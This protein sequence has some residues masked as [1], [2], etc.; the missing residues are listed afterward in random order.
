MSG[1][2][3]TAPRPPRM[4]SFLFAIG[5]MGL[6]GLMGAFA[7]MASPWDMS[8]MMDGGHMGGM[9]GKG[10]D[11]SGDPTRQGTATESLSMEDFAYSPGNLLVPVGARLTWINHDSAPHSATDANG[12]WD[13]GV[14]AKGMSA[15]L[16]FDMAGTFDYYCS[17][18]PSMKARI[19]VQ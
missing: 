18:H 2:S 17:V 12:T 4:L 13:T 11:A 14:L 8:G 7:W 1:S 15:T 6:L 5:L 19:V 3:R 10:K 16:T 9:M